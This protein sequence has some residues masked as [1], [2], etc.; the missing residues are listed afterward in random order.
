MQIL[1]GGGPAK[2]NSVRGAA[3]RAELS[4]PR[5]DILKTI[6]KGFL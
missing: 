6:S 5:D 2:Q 1:L 4:K 3:A